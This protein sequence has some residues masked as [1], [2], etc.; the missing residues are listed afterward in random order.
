MTAFFGRQGGAL[1]A[2]GNLAHRPAMNWR[3]TVI[4]PDEIK[5][6]LALDG[7]AT[8]WRT[9]SAIA[10]Q[11][12]LSESRVAQIFAKY[13]LTLTRR[14]EVPSISGQPLVGLIEKVGV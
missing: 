11:T 4:D 3:N 10:R 2:A 7:P 13:D 14:A 1:D 9:V 12:G 5:V 8:T 6:F